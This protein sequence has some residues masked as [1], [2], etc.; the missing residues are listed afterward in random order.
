VRLVLQNV[1]IALPGVTDM[2]TLGQPGKF[3]WCF[4]ENI[5]A[6]PWPPYHTTRGYAAEENAV[7]ALAVSG[8]QEVVLTGRSAQDYAACLAQKLAPPAGARPRTPED[9]L[10]VVAG[11]V[12]IKA[13]L[14]PG[15]GMGSLPVTKPVVPR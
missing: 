7:T 6:S 10:F 9:L 3:G 13:A 12:G 4:T 5:E 15:W 11:G 1:G 2:A 8:S 14:L